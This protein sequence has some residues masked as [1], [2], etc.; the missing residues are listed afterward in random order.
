MAISPPDSFAYDTDFFDSHLNE[1]LRSAREVV[2]LLLSLLSPKSVVDVGC[3]IGTCLAAFREQGI[4][5][6]LG[7]DGDYV[8]RARLLIPESSF[9]PH[10]LEQ[11]AGS[12]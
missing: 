10:D 7:I 9:L 11:A 12:G 4:E 6:L 3:G 1:S 8:D 2:P 5:D